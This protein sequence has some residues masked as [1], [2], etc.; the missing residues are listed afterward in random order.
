MSKN[1]G[2][3]FGSSETKGAKPPHPDWE[4][5]VVA[6]ISFVVVVA[7][8]WGPR[9]AWRLARHNARWDHY[10]RT[11]LRPLRQLHQGLVYGAWFFVGLTALGL[12]CALLVALVWRWRVRCLRGQY[13]QLVVPRPQGREGNARANPEAPYVSWDRLIATLQEAGGRGLPAYLATELWGDGSGRVQ[14]GVWLPAHVQ[15]QREAVRRLMTAE[16]PQARLVDAPDPLLA[17]LQTAGTARDAEET[18]GARWYASAL[19]ILAARDY[20]PLLE[21]GLA[22]RGLVAALRPPRAVLASGVSVIVSPAPFAWARR[23]HQLVQRWRWISRYQRRYDERY[24]QETDAISLKAQQAHA[25]V[26]LRVHVVATTKAAA[27]AECRSVITT[28]TS[29]RKRYA[30]VTQRWRARQVRVRPVR[31]TTLPAAG[32]NRAPFQ[33]LPRLMGLFP[34]V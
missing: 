10:L 3:F 4:R 12:L 33:S 6:A 31:G 16:R 1:S 21:D 13:L 27:Q 28:L 8:L 25:R 34:F 5:W 22:Q 24:K 14:W 11:H 29:S 23:V 7:A 9:V 30:R 20:Y 19:L 26:C 15:R 32:R 2:M 18:S 17:A